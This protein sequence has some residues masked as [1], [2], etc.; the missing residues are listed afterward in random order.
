MIKKRIIT[1]KKLLL[2]CALLGLLTLGQTGIA[3]A[4]YW[5]ARTKE[6]SNNVLPQSFRL[7]TMAKSDQ[8][9]R[10]MFG[11]D[12]S[13]TSVEWTNLTYVVSYD[14]T[15]WTNHTDTVKNLR[16]Y[17]S[18]NISIPVI[19]ADPD[20][21]FWM[22]NRGQDS[23]LKFDG[24]N[25]E[26]ITKTTI[27][28]DV[29]PGG[30]PSGINFV[31]NMFGDSASRR[32]YTVV[33]G[34]D[35]QRY[36]IYFDK[37]DS[38]WH[39]YSASGGVLN[40]ALYPGEIYGVRNEKDGSIWFWEYSKTEADQE[41]YG[42][43]LWQMD[44]SGN[45]NHYNSENSIVPGVISE[46]FPDS[47]GKIWVSTAD[48][49]LFT[50]SSNEGWSNWT[51]ENTNLFSNRVWTIQEDSDNRIWIINLPDNSA[52]SKGGVC[53]YDPVNNEWQYYTSKNGEDVVET[54][55]NAF[56]SG[57]EMWI[58]S[59]Y[60]NGGT[61]SL[62]KEDEHAAIYGQTSGDY[63]AK[64]GFDP[65]KKKK[66]TTT[67]KNKAVAIYKIARV[68]VKKK[69]KTRKTLVYKTGTTQWYKSLNLDVGKYQIVS[70]G[71]GKKKRTRTV[72]IANG[73]PYRLDLR[74]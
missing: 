19:Y 6:S 15:N 9:V 55:T 67:S 14:G 13:D 65:A 68:K 44:A 24:Q 40:S 33:D 62:V 54:A 29:F 3:K 52:D 10:L 69:Y 58:Q 42:F 32:I 16:E 7:E 37:N 46:V 45:W 2:G 30:T 74:Y 47:Q 25:W 17:P 72:N 64:T 70:R 38:R 56:I 12:V 26:K 23:L 31:G 4:D 60:G 34:N 21:V 43:G 39:R 51:K 53:V 50:H 73:N 63:V 41:E 57:D 5:E 11:Y 59:N 1:S 35:N 28:Q 18:V 48:H 20:G 49:G 8:G 36:L 27:L 61:Y 71:G 66:K 22:R